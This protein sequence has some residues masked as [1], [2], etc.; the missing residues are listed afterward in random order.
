MKFEEHI[1][2]ITDMN[3]PHNILF[4]TLES[5]RQVGKHR[6]QRN[7]KNDIEMAELSCCTFTFAHENRTPDCRQRRDL[8]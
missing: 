8:F 7:L 2:C 1:G 3:N 5:K 4:N 6:W